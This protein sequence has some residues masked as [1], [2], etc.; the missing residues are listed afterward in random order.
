MNRN[1][2]LI[3][4]AQPISDE[5][6]QKLKQGTFY[7]FTPKESKLKTLELE[8]CGINHDNNWE[9]HLERLEGLLAAMAKTPIKDSLEDILVG[10]CGLSEEQVREIMDRHGFHN[11]KEIY[12]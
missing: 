9:E 11:I 1:N 5:D 6:I 4:L 7:S 12:V 8:G 2:R 10:Y 3:I